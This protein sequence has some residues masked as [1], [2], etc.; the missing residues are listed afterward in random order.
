MKSTIANF[1]RTKQIDSFQKLNFLLF[2][3]Q[4]PEM[5]GTSQEFAA[6]LFLN[7]LVVEDIMADLQK[8]G[9]LINAAQRWKL[10]DE[11]EV[12]THLQ[13]LVRGFECPLARQN[14]L[15]QINIRK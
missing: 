3:H 10:S 1:I 15:A 9:L 7:E 11:P 4:H 8:V 2:L 12:K 6:R 13:Y 14:I 5:T